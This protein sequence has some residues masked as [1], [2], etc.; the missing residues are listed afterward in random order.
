MDTPLRKSLIG[1]VAVLIFFHLGTTAWAQGKAADS[2]A[3]LAAY[4]GT[5]REQ[6]LLAGARAE[7][8]VTWYTSLA[9]SSYKELAKGFEAKYPGVQIEPYR[10]TSGDLMTKIVAEAEAKKYLADAIETTLPVLR[11]MRENKMLT[12]YTSPALSRFPPK[13]KEDAGRGLFFWAIDRETYMG[14]GYN[15]S[16]IPPSAVP[17]NYG[18]LLQPALKGKIGFATSDTGTRT[19]GSMLKHKGEEFLRKLK[20]Q[21]ISL[22]SVSG[23]A[24]ADMVISGEV[25]LSPT[26]FR[27]HALESKAKGAPIDWVPME[28]V[29]T[30][31]GGVG[32][33]AQ[34]PHPHA[35]ALLVDFLFSAEAQKIL[36]DLEYGSPF[37]PVSFKLWY[38]ESGM[39]TAQYDK[40]SARWEKL[41]REIGRK[42]L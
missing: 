14:V 23:R 25:G 28:V 18:D 37:R 30:N 21:N 39:S 7:G 9:G 6:R 40:E 4:K 5:D 38:P 19:V 12:A 31:A 26:I 1:C 2:I 16:I 15:T 11:Y 20:A 13:A 10:G 22:Y 33:T 3:E 27:D 24:L 32:L 34:A 42:P 17:K 8:K 35:A 41:L 36:A 29:P